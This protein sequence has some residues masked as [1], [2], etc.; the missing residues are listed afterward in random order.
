VEKGQKILKL[1]RKNNLPLLSISAAFR[2]IMN[3]FDNTR[4]HITINIKELPKENPLFMKEASIK[5]TK[6]TMVQMI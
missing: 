3:R 2:R 4:K 5:S 1:R 6:A